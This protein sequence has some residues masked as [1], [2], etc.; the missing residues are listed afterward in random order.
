M[1]REE[2]SP[3][4]EMHVTTASAN[5]SNG[6]EITEVKQFTGILDPISTIDVGNGTT[7]T[8]SIVSNENDTNAVPLILYFTFWLLIMTAT[9]LIAYLRVKRHVKT[10]CEYSTTKSDQIT[11]K[12][13]LEFQEKNNVEADPRGI[14]IQTQNQIT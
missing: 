14:Q 10:G 7:E 11:N 9:A 13:R 5:K 6:A 2:I 12:H 3:P 1:S 4:H 8:T